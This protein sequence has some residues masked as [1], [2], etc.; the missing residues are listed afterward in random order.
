MAD[1]LL[2]ES[3]IR[4]WRIAEGEE[5]VPPYGGISVSLRNPNYS[6]TSIAV[7]PDGGG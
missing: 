3:R 2:G 1:R 4:L 7:T 6:S 5:F